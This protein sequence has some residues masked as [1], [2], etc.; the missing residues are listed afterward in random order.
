MGFGG[1]KYVPF[2]DFEPSDEVEDM[3]NIASG[4][5]GCGVLRTIAHGRVCKGM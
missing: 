3:R 4:F 1:Q 5:I 2:T